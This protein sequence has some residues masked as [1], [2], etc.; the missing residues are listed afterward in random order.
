MRRRLLT[1][2][3]P[4]HLSLHPYSTSEKPAYEVHCRSCQEKDSD[5]LTI[6]HV[7]FFTLSMKSSISLS[8]C[9]LTQFDL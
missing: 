3:L 5:C 9:F 7:R 4:G 1:A 2:K 8:L 6:D